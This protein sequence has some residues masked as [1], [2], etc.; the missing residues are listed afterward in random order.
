MWEVEEQEKRKSESKTMHLIPTFPK[1]TLPET[2]RDTDPKLK[3]IVPIQKP[4]T[5]RRQ[6]HPSHGF[7]QHDS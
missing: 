7:P 2:I 6:K 1:E 3:P 4:K 5:E